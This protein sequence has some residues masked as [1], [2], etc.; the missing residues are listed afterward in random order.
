MLPVNRIPYKRQIISPL[1]VNAG[2]NAIFNTNTDPF[3]RFLLFFITFSITASTALDLSVDIFIFRHLSPVYFAGSFYFLVLF[4]LKQFPTKSAPLPVWLRIILPLCAL[5]FAMILISQNWVDGLADTSRWAYIFFIIASFGKFRLD[6]SGQRVALAGI[7]GGALYHILYVLSLKNWD[8]L[9]PDSLSTGLDRNITAATML[10]GIW[11]CIQ[12]FELFSKKTGV[13]L[14]LIFLLTFFVFCM[15]I[16]YSRSS[17]LIAII[18]LI[19]YT[20]SRS[21]NVYVS[22]LVVFFAL[23]S[24]YLVTNTQTYSDRILLSRI[25]DPDAFS[26]GRLSIWKGVLEGLPVTYWLGAGTANLKF[27]LSNSP[28][29]LASSYGRFV[30]LRAASHSMFLKLL[31][32]NGIEGALAYSFFIL[33]M[34]K[35]AWSKRRVDIFP[36][37]GGVF[38]FVLGLFFD[39]MFVPWVLLAIFL[40]PYL[41]L[42]E[43]LPSKNQG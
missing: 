23:G 7:V 8:I 39:Y 41:C 16:T 20:L 12:L 27:V 3:W 17:L 4:S 2:P 13:R 5:M 31:A 21:R 25:D 1:S 34:L 42:D 22:L 37:V 6:P 15:L 9:S 43:T 19:I 29:F 18:T 38:C 10:C 30:G 14:W 28:S 11:A 32:E 24:L 33:G 35:F 40:G 36:F 26:E